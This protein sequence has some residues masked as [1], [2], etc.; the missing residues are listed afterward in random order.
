MV[1]LVMIKN[2]AR[3]TLAQEDERSHL[4]RASR[5]SSGWVSGGFLTQYDLLGHGFRLEFSKPLVSLWDESLNLP[6]LYP[7]KIVNLSESNE[8]GLSYYA[9]NLYIHLILVNN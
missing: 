6:R 5:I 3:D 7:Y 8:R 4:L 1:F 2:R 9:F